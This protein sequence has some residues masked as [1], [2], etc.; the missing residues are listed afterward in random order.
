MNGRDPWA[1]TG[2]I[3]SAFAD[4]AE[5]GGGCHGRS[6]QQQ[7]GHDNPAASNLPWD[8]PDRPD[9]L[10]LR[11]REVPPVRVVRQDRAVQQ[12]REGRNFVSPR[13]FDLAP[14]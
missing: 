9:P 4:R 10:V 14:R 13:L 5:G 6:W 3:P 8:R 2:A 12:A 11:G 7:T 1:Q